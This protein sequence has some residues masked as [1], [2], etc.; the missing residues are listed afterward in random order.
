MTVM[1]RVFSNVAKLETDVYK[2]YDE[3]VVFLFA[4]GDCVFHSGDVQAV[5][6]YTSYPVPLSQTYDRE[7]HGE[8]EF[9][10]VGYSLASGTSGVVDLFAVGSTTDG[11]CFTIIGHHSEIMG[12]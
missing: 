2:H 7:V 1:D 11:E 5:G 8:E 12:Q 10:Q 9:T 3:S 6:R 4:S